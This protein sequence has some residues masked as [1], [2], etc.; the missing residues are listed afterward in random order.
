RQQTDI[1]S[2]ETRAATSRFPD[3]STMDSLAVYLHDEF[4][5]G[6]R[7]TLDLGGRLTRVD[8]DLPVADR[9]IGASL[10]VNDL[11]GNVGALYD[12]SAGMKVV[13]NLG[14][15]FRAPNIFDLGTLGVRPG[16]RFNIGNPD[17]M[18]EE[19]IT[20]D[21]GLKFAG[22]NFIGE[23]MFWNA[24][25]RDK[26]TSVL[27]G[28][29]DDEGRSI[30]QSRNAA[31]VDLWGFEV[32]GRLQLNGDQLELSGSLNYTRGDETDGTSQPADRV[33][34]LNGRIGV[35]Y[36]RDADRWLEVFTT[37]AAKQD[38]LSDRDVDDPRINP[39]GTAGWAALNLVAGW[40]LN[41][42]WN[43]NLRVGNLLDK[44]YRE[45][46]SG[47]DAP[48]RDLGITIRKVF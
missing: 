29:I 12:L 33:P 45:H 28:A 26:I 43:L 11:T 38:R 20:A 1:I 14:R 47:I 8:V 23:A 2:R 36:R 13:A 15:G 5:L 19:V 9:D 39:A 6:D 44:R 3:G 16:N 18:P 22:R 24:D 41:H 7:L 27:T 4:H 37:F 10:T 17:L 34:P 21:L 30:V 40:N 31:T 48:G 42:S 25:Y 46:G 32:G 35:L